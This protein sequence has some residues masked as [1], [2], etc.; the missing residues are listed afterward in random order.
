MKDATRKLSLDQ[1][2]TYQITVP[3][4]LDDSWSEWLEGMTIAVERAGDRLTITTLTGV[5]ADQAALHGLLSRLYSLGLPLISVSLVLLEVKEQD[6]VRSKR[7]SCMKESHAE[8]VKRKLQVTY[9]GSQ[10]CTAFLEPQAKAIALDCPYTSKGEEFSPMNAVG[11]GLAGCMLISMGTL[12]M[13]NQLDLA[14]TAV[15]VE[16]SATEQRIQAIDLTFSMPSGF[17][18]VNRIKLERA[19]ELCPIEHS[20]HPEIPISVRYSYPE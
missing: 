6:D 12:A 3:G 16:I 8:V 17:S 19:A 2:A 1:P 15:D 11:A 18:K 9:D 14:G 4:R 7:R 20:F 10:H 13:R 5:V